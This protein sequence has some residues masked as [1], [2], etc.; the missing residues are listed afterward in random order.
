MTQQAAQTAMTEAGVMPA[1]IVVYELHDCFSTNELI[2][3][4]APSL[5]L[6]EG[7]RLGPSS[8]WKDRRTW[9]R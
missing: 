8:R 7:L 4:D 1:D 5:S 2:L 9:F 3:L 6:P